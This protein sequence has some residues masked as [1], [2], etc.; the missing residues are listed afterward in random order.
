MAILPDAETLLPT[1]LAFGL[2]M[3]LVAGG[4]V[5]AWRK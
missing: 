4:L 3:Y 1:V 2:G 5:L